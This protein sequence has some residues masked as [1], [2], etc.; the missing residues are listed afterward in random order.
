MSRSRNRQQTLKFIINYY[1]F[2]QKKRNFLS[3]QLKPRQI[4]R[5]LVMKKPTTKQLKQLCI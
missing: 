3:K 5:E 4:F 1:I 2:R